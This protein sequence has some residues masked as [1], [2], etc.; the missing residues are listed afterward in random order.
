MSDPLPSTFE[1][2]S[3]VA[4]THGVTPLNITD[5]TLVQYN[6]HVYKIRELLYKPAMQDME[7]RSDTSS[8][9]ESVKIF[10]S[11]PKVVDSLNGMRFGG[12]GNSVPGNMRFGGQGNSVP[13]N[14]STVWPGH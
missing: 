10:P 5:D 1:L 6:G 3:Y 9:F 7:G 14:M 12:Q 13:G 2:D 4:P 8:N 11:Q